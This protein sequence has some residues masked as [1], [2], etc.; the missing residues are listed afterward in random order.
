MDSL[1]GCDWNS[2]RSVDRKGHSVNTQTKMR[3]KSKGHPCYIVVKNWAELC[4]HGVE[5]WAIWCGTLPDSRA[6]GSLVFAVAAVSCERT[7]CCQ[8]LQ[9]TVTKVR[10]ESGR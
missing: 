6:L 8:E 1:S 2:G 9:L 4:E 5:E 3:N 7:N 10:P